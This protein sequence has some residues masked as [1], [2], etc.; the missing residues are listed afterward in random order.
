ITRDRGVG[1]LVVSYTTNSGAMGAAV[2]G[3]D[4][5]A[6]AGSVTFADGQT[7][8]PVTV[9]PIQD[10]ANDPSELIRLTLTTNVTNAYTLGPSSN[11]AMTFVD[12]DVTGDMGWLVSNNKP[13]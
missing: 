3:T 11:A 10:A 7:A 8:I 13:T 1:S 12:D 4:Y 2:S 9:I 6:L 5:S